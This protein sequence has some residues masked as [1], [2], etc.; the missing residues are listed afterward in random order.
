[1][2]RDPPKVGAFH[3]SGASDRASG[4][5]EEAKEGDIFATAARWGRRSG[6]DRTTIAKNREEALFHAQVPPERTARLH[7]ILLLLP[8]TALLVLAVAVLGTDRL[9]RPLTDDEKKRFGA[10]LR[11]HDY[12]RMRLIALRFAYKLTRS[13][14]RAQNL[15]GRADLR[16]VRSG[17]DPDQVPLERALCRLVWSEWTNELSESATAERATE[18]FI[19]ELEATEGL[20]LVRPSPDRS[21]GAGKA[22]QR[23]EWSVPSDD[24]KITELETAREARTKASVKLEKL[25]AMFEKAGDEVNL[26]WLKFQLADVTDLQQMAKESGRDVAD[27]YAAAKRRK[28]AVQ[29]LLAN[30]HGVDWVEEES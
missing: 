17:W 23:P 30:E 28:R 7:P 22:A 16:L 6:C 19:R 14:V 5:G 2:A 20:K 29:R 25:R 9:G 3:R 24:R 18:G 27:F 13:K 1:M 10:L 11:E 8:L 15:M 26:L 12:P 21:Q 4:G